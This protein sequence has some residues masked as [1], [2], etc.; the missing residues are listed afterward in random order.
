MQVTECFNLIKHLLLNTKQYTE[1]LTFTPEAW[2][3][4][5]CYIHLIGNLEITGLGKI[6][7]NKITDVKLLTQE[8]RAAYVECDDDAISDF[9]QQHPTEAHLWQLDWHSHVDMSTSPSGTDWKNYAEMQEIRMGNTFPFLVINKSQEMTAGEYIGGGKYH[10][11]TINKPESIPLTQQQMKDIYEQCKADI[12]LHCTQYVATVTYGIPQHKYYGYNTTNYYGVASGRYSQKKTTEQCLFCSADLTTQY[13]RER[14][15]CMECL[16]EDEGFATQQCLSCQAALTAEEEEQGEG[17]CFN[18]L[19]GNYE[20]T[21]DIP[22]LV[23][24]TTNRRKTNGH[25]RNQRRT[26]R[27]KR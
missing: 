25:Q 4:I 22:V 11:L 6:E 5:N 15:H 14:K 8:V 7:D 13:E 18:C 3:K 24:Q 16:K 19:I 23:Q 26:Q 21:R 2:V 12:Q 20:A 27:T 1:P 17:Y 10:R 9:I